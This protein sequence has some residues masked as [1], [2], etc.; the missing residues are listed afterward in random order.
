MTGSEERTGS[1]IGG[2]RAV[3][4][5]DDGRVFTGTTFGAVGQ[6]LGE[7]VFTTGMT[8]YQET[9]TDPSYHGQIVV[10]TAPM[11]GNTGW[12]DEDDESSGIQ[13]AG[14]AVRDPARMPSNWRSQRGLDDAL[15]EQG[16]VG[17]A[18]I[19]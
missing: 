8:G 4:V 19:D 17:I 1:R 7:A 6:T 2:A 13:V 3:L 11:I 10:Q 14:Y 9:L 16:I 12:N 15:R 18:G 5:L